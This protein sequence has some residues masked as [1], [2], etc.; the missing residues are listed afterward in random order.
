MGQKAGSFYR[1]VRNKKVNVEPSVG[2][3]FGWLVTL[4]GHPEQFWF[5]DVAPQAGA[6]FVLGQEIYFN[7]IQ[8]RPAKNV[9]FTFLKACGGEKATDHT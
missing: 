7:K 2:W 8:P 4:C 1:I 9:F 5:A 3:V 6:A